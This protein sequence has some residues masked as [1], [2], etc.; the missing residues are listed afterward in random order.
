MDERAGGVAPTLWEVLRE[1][2]PSVWASLLVGAGV[3]GCAVVSVAAMRDAAFDPA[4]WSTDP[5]SPDDVKAMRLLRRGT[6]MSTVSVTLASLLTFAFDLSGANGSVSS[7]GVGMAW[8]NL[9]SYLLDRAFATDDAQARLSEEGATPTR[10]LRAS[11]DQLTTSSFAKYGV[12]VAIDM[13]LVHHIRNELLSFES[14]PW[15]RYTVA[16]VPLDAVLNVVILNGVS[17]I[18]YLSYSNAL[19]FAWAYAPSGGD[20]RDAIMRLTLLGTFMMVSRKDWAPPTRALVGGVV[21]ALLLAPL[22]LGDEPADGVGGWVYAGVT[23]SCFGAAAY[24]SS[25]VAG[26]SLA[27]AS[28]AGAIGPFL[29]G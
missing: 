8:G 26:W 10:A 4:T 7:N 12:L 25:S 29:V 3:V 21:L 2:G 20:F 11:L 17:S 13:L 24:S 28:A 9:I 23:L 16:G 14:L 5:S 6:L 18:V 1:R 22:A 19:R 27:A 15:M